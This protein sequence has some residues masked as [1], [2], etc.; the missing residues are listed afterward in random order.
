MTHDII[1]ECSDHD[2]HHLDDETEED[3]GKNTK[4]ENGSR[5][6][7][8]TLVEGDAIAPDRKTSGEKNLQGKEEGKSSSKESDVDSGCGSSCHEIFAAEPHTTHAQLNVSSLVY[9]HAQKINTIETEK[10]I[11]KVPGRSFESKEIKNLSISVPSNAPHETNTDVC[12]GVVEGPSSNKYESQLQKSGDSFEEL[13][14]LAKDGMSTLAR[15]RVDNYGKKSKISD[16]FQASTVVDNSCRTQDKSTSTNDENIHS[17]IASQQGLDARKVD[18][19]VK[20]IPSASL[21]SDHTN[22]MGKI[23]YRNVEENQSDTSISKFS[24]YN[25]TESH[26]DK[27]MGTFYTEENQPDTPIIAGKN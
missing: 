5:K 26:S 21:C 15:K 19:G 24:I 11:N 9:C 10:N 25:T 6:N 14:Q 17:R 3:N 20:R 16:C 8:Q 7:K 27:I 2:L 1:E 22:S 23:L 13:I 12:D 18:S 4:N